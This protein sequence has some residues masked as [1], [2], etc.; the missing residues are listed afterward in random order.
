MTEVAWTP[1]SDEPQSYRPEM[2]PPPK[3]AGKLLRIGDRVRLKG[4]DPFVGCWMTGLVVNI[5]PPRYGQ[6]VR[7]R[8]MFDN[9]VICIIEASK[10]VVTTPIPRF[11]VRP[12]IMPPLPRSA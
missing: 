10:F 12:V 5:A 8:V 2:P 3:V 4:C 11:A 6:P 1:P 9:D 7:A